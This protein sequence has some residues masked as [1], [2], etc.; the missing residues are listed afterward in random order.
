MRLL[1]HQDA[2]IRFPSDEEKRI[3]ASMV[4]EREPLVSDVIGFLDGVSF[5][6]ACAE[7][8]VSQSIKYNGYGHDTYV[9]CLY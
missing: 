7:D 9:T 1:N 8:D 2:M 4:K 3:Y 5:P 6:C